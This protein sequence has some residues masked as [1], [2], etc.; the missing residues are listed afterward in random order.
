MAAALS[1]VSA[2]PVTAA[3]RQ[4]SRLDFNEAWEAFRTVG[5]TE[6]SREARLGEAVLLTSV[7]PRTAAR[8]DEA[9]A[10]LTA[11]AAEDQRDDTDAAARFFLGRIAQIYAD[12]INYAEAAR[13][14]AGLVERHPGHPLAETARVRLSIVELLAAT[15]PAEKRAALAA[16]EARL[17]RLA[18][19]GPRIDL[20]FVLAEA[21]W[22]SAADA[23]RALEHLLAADALGGS[24]RTNVQIDQWITIGELA[25]RLGRTDVARRYFSRA[26]AEAPRDERAD[27][28]RGVIAGLERE[29]AG[30]AGERTP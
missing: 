11:L 20:H 7:A 12:P 15:N 23:S 13:H 29:A 28:L 24:V 3:W 21:W 18:E 9:R 14:Y 6:S 8:L 1:V 2:D 4:A 5:R 26:V 27:E 17:E 22:R 16:A 10:A 30:A 25:R 19:P